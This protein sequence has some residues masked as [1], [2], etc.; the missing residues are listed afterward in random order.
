MTRHDITVQTRGHSVKRIPPP[1]HA[2][3][4]TV[5]LPT[6]CYRRAQWPRSTRI[7]A[8]V[9]WRH[10]RLTDIQNRFQITSTILPTLFRSIA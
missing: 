1:R 9:A 2:E 5:S 8:V 10:S 3:I 4:G 6:N 7:Q